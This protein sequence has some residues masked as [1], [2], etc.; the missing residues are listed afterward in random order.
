MLCVNSLSDFPRVCIEPVARRWK[1]IRLT[2]IVAWMMLPTV[3]N[4]NVDRCEIAWYITYKFRSTFGAASFSIELHHHKYSGENFI[5][6]FCIFSMPDE[7]VNAAEAQWNRANSIILKSAFII[8][9][10]M[11]NQWNKLEM[12]AQIVRWIDLPFIWLFFSLSF[13]FFLYLSFFFLYRLPL[14]LSFAPLC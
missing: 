13:S 4:W 1:H 5:I 7:C 10:V 3:C 11:K 12:S 6:G 9:K 8:R 14:S 2:T